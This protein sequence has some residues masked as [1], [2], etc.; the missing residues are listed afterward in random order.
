MVKRK[1]TRHQ[2]DRR[3]VYKQEDAWYAPAPLFLP[4]MSKL[5]VCQ[6]LSSRTG[7]F[8]QAV[9]MCLNLF[10]LLN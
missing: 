6:N 1:R 7:W 10:Y 9:G 4:R 2:T 5:G 3:I 8:C